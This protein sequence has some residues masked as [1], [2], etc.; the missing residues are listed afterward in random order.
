[1]PIKP[2]AWIKRGALTVRFDQGIPLGLVL[3]SVPGF[4]H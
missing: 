4:S 2:G 1:M 3:A